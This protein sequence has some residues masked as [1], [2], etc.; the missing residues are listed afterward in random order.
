M[1]AYFPDTNIF[2]D[3]GRNLAVRQRL[4]QAI[5]NGAHFVIAPP[6]LIELTRGMVRTAQTHFQ[7]DKRV[8]VW[9]RDNNF[10]ILPLPF[11][12]MANI[13][14]SRTPQRSTVLPDHYRQQIEMIADAADFD[15]FLNRSRG[16]VWQDIYRADAIHEAELDREVGAIRP[17]VK[18]GRGQDYAEPL[19][20][21]FG[22]PGC[23]PR[24]EIVARKFSA[25]LEFLEFSIAK[26][27]G[28]A[29]LRRNDPGFYTDFQLLFYLADTELI[30]VTRE[31]FARKIRVSPQRT[32]IVGME[33]LP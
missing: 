9:L 3:F 12:F 20:R 26:A 1:P 4:E 14:R 13:L 10:A 5:G 32:R 23:R 19:S 15:D 24:P 2:I 31:N 17:L 6:A 7:N 30:F 16:T 8:F 11:P 27:S 33:A 22:V 29:N 21:K 18:R 28:G 25:A